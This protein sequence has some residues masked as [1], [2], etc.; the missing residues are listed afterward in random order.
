[1]MG[2][3]GSSAWS[4]PAGCSPAQG[5]RYVPIEE[6]VRV[7]KDVAYVH[8]ET[9]TLLEQQR[10]GISGALSD[11]GDKAKTAVRPPPARSPTEGA[12]PDA[13]L[14]KRTG[15]DVEDDDGAVVVPAG[16]RVTSDDIERARAADKLGT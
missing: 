13:L 7:G 15:R 2:Q 11:V 10:G 4:C 9:A 5:T 16:R 1:M 8:P 3:G 14:G 6:L 12:R